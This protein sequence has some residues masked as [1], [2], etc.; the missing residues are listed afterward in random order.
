MRPSASP[1]GISWWMMPRP[2][3]IH[4]MSPAPMLPWFP[5]LSPC[6]TVPART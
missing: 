6:S 4:W 2:A 5:M 3:V 1:V